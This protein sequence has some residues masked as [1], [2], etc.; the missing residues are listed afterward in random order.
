[1]VGLAQLAGFGVKAKTPGTIAGDTGRAH[2][3]GAG[4]YRVKRLGDPTSD[5]L[6]VARRLRSLAPIHVSLAV[7]A[8]VVPGLLSWQQL[9]E[10]VGS[11]APTGRTLVALTPVAGLAVC[12]VQLDP[13]A[14]VLRPWARHPRRADPRHRPRLATHSDGLAQRDARGGD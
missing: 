12:A 5:E 9:G 2:I 3:G 8:G 11:A 7:L 10:D 14:R 4:A 6:V 1:M 13:R